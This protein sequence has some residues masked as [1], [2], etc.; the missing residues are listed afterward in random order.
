M[1]ENERGINSTKTNR[2]CVLSFA[3]VYGCDL[4]TAHC[5]VKRVDKFSLEAAP[6]TAS[7]GWQ[8]RGWLREIRSGFPGCV[9]MTCAIVSITPA[10]KIKNNQIQMSFL[11]HSCRS[12]TDSEKLTAT[13]VTTSRGGPMA[14]DRGRHDSHMDD[15]DKLLDV[16]GPSQSPLLPLSH[17]LQ[18][19]QAHPHSGKLASYC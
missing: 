7:C 12:S 17:S 16:V 14:L 2:C 18:Q 5:D 9:L 3:I 11:L 19:L 15:D 4:W 6:S 1:Q 8:F 10:H 13:H